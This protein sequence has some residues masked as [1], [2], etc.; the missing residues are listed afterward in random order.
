M[1]WLER[2]TITVTTLFE[3]SVTLLFFLFFFSFFFYDT[4]LSLINKY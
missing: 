4:L 2:E 1:K 3:L